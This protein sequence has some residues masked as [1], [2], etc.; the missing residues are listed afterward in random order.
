M[1]KFPKH[2]IFVSDNTEAEFVNEITGA[3]VKERVANYVF[4]KAKTNKGVTVSLFLSQLER[5]LQDKMI[6]ING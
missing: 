5:L 3:R 1:S 6:V 4:T 2:I